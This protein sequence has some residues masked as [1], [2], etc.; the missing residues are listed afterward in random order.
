VQVNLALQLALSGSVTMLAIG[1]AKATTE[2]GGEAEGIHDH[3]VPAHG[4]HQLARRRVRAL[5][6][7][8]RALAGS[9]AATAPVAVDDL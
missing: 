1:E 3:R 6:R 9:A 5:Q 2:T 8:D 7:E 4:V